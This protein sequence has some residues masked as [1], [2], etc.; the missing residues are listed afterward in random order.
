M[1]YF[2][3]GRGGR[4]HCYFCVCVFPVQLRRTQQEGPRKKTVEVQGTAVALPSVSFHDAPGAKYFASLRIHFLGV[5]KSTPFIIIL[6]A[7]LL[8]CVP[9]IAFNASEG[10]GNS[11][12]PVTHWILELI[13]GTLY[14]F[15]VGI[16][17]YY[18]GILV[19]K[20]RDTRMDEITDSL[21]APEWVSYAS[22][23][24]ALIGIVPVI[25]LV[26]FASRYLPRPEGLSQWTHCRTRRAWILFCLSVTASPT[27]T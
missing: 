21:P 16:I 26:V 12:L 9:A 7:A 24:T 1:R 23:L 5:V 19:W 25:Q 20:N 8:N 13:A 6:C 27:T 15:T 17:T 22:R 18:A 11:S 4:G 10:Y 3:F 14:M 2:S